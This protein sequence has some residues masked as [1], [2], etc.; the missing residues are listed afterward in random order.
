MSVK[1][2]DQGAFQRLERG[3][4]KLHEFYHD[5]G[6][7][8]SHPSNKEHYR[9]YLVSTGKA[10][11]QVIPDVTIDGKALFATMMGETATIDPYVFHALER[12]KAS[13]RFILAALTNNFNLPEDD[14]QE[15]EAMGAGAAEKLKS[16]FDYFFESRVIGLRKPDP[17]IYQLACETIGIQP[18][19]AIFLDDIGMNLRAANQL[20]ITT[21]QVHMGRSLEAV[22][23]L[24]RLTGLDLLK[25][26]KL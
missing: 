7:Q 15:A 2:G 16:L 17:R 25:E 1:Q 6:Q 12:L 23:Q 24:E 19:E 9:S 26:S 8:L 3:E 14:L 20:G 4:I 10:I 22:K 11:P 21:I 13:G 5:F 18:H